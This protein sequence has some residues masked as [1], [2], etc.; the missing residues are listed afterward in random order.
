MPSRGSRELSA[1]A[2]RGTD[3]GSQT[4]DVSLL[5]RPAYDL[6]ATSTG[7]ACGRTK[8][9]EYY[10]ACVLVDGRRG[11]VRVSSLDPHRIDTSVPHPARRYNYW[12]GGK[13]HF[14]ADRDSGDAIAELFP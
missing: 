10:D 12:L 6:G 1:E 9:G 7:S 8:P 13:D 3:P 11:S 2:E 4:G 5:V 14:Q